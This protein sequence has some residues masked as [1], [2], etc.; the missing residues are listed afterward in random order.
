MVLRECG[1]AVDHGQTRSGPM[2]RLRRFPAF[3]GQHLERPT[4]N[5]HCRKL[6]AHPNAYCEA[7]TWRK[8]KKNGQ[9]G[10]LIHRL[11]PLRIFTS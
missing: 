7:L 2:A 8:H 1:F 6:F 10:Q 11:T 9:C 5:R 3:L 4:I